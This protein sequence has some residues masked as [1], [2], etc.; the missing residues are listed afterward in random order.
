MV[1]IDTS[2][3][4]DP[5]RAWFEKLVKR[6]PAAWTTDQRKFMDDMRAEARKRSEAYAEQFEREARAMVESQW[7]GTHP[8]L[9]DPEGWEMEYPGT[10]PG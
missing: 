1:K 9:D 6:D 8:S 2:W 4:T 3:M 7:G 10:E 5:Q